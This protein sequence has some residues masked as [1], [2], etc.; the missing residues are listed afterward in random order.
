MFNPA[1][2][3]PLLHHLARRG[4]RCRGGNRGSAPD[5]PVLVDDDPAERGEVLRAILAVYEARA[6]D[7]AEAISRKWA[8]PS[9]WRSATMQVPAAAI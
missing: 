9:T 4:R 5:I 7:M 2:E 8:R 1:T 3:E 6:A